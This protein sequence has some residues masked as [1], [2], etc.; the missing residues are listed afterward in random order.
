MVPS[1]RRMRAEAYRII[2]ARRD[3]EGNCHADLNAHQGLI[4]SGA[5]LPL[6]FLTEFLRKGEPTEARR[7]F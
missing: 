1:R 4:R 2:L 6:V 3:L 5:T 7:P